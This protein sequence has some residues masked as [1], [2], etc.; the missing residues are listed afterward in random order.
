MKLNNQIMLITYA[1]S[2]GKNLKELHAALNKYFRGAVGGVHILPFFP[3]SADRGFAPTRYDAVDPDFGAFA[4]IEALGKE[5]YLMFDFMVNHIS[6]SSD[7]YH[8]F[9]A[10]KDGSKYRDFFIRY[11]DFWQNGEPTDA[12]VDAIYKRKA[13]KRFV[14]RR[15]R[16]ILAMRAKCSTST[17]F[18]LRHFCINLSL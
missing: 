12:Q 15:Y 11:K 8:D 2:M 1:D 4:D 5:Y 13:Q 16:L 18:R 6:R 9:L 14:S 10:K 17:L 3:S 7:I